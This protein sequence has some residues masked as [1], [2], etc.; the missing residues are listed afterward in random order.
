ML[1]LVV[2]SALSGILIMAVSEIAKRN[3]ALGGLIASLPLIS[4]LGILWLWKDT[5]DTTRI[6]DHAEATF[7]FVLPSLPMFLIF[8]AM[9]RHGMNFWL[10]LIVSCAVTML[11]YV[12]TL[13]ILPKMRIKI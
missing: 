3:P 10:A 9:L 12:I 11:L 1:Y 4:I 13:W 5:A 8:P 2:K 6:A 7:W